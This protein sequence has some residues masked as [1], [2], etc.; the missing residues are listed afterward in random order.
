MRIAFVTFE[1]PPII[2]G[3]A[4]IYAAHIVEELEKLGHQI[5]VF[6]PTPNATDSTEYPPSANL[7]IWHV[8]VHETLPF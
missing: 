8:P 7:Q 4:G 5:I 3:G 2:H 1:Y 6:T